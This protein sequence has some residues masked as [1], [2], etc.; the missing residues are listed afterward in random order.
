MN[1]TNNPLTMSA[2]T[3]TGSVVSKDIDSNKNS[4]TTEQPRTSSFSYA[5]F[6]LFICYH[7]RNLLKRKS[8][9]NKDY[10]ANDG[11][12]QKIE[13]GLEYEDDYSVDTSFYG[14]ISSWN[15]FQ[16]FDL[17]DESFV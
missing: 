3:S 8:R 6:A 16:K 12:N 4:K 1:D 14:S 11:L 13:Y 17:D 10:F 9:Q 15:E 7:A 5:W 2:P